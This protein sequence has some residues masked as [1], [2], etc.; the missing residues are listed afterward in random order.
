MALIII[1]L[2]MFTSVSLVHNTV[3]IIGVKSTD[4]KRS[5]KRTSLLKFCCVHLYVHIY[6]YIYVLY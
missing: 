5:T 4:R 6:M 3:F 1:V 2:C